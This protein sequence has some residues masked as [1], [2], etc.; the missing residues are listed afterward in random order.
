MSGLR[1]LG[2]GLVLGVCLMLAMG[3]A[4]APGAN[5]AAPRYQL[6]ASEENQSYRFFILD[7][8]T[9]K[10]YARRVG[11]HQVPDGGMTIEELLRQR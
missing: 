10:V 9:N 7:H 11:N 1:Q 3:Q 5:A 2:I 6:V 8:Q 4:A